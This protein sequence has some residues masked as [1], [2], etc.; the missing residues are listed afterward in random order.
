MVK[1]DGVEYGGKRLKIRHVA[2]HYYVPI[3]VG[4]RR[5]RIGYIKHIIQTKARWISLTD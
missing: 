2:N 4:G 1:E 3:V 5:G